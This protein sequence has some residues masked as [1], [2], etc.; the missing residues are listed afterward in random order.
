MEHRLVADFSSHCWS[1]G[2]STANAAFH[3]H[4]GQVQEMRSHT[5]YH[6]VHEMHHHI[7]RV[8]HGQAKEFQRRGYAPYAGTICRFSFI[9]LL[10]IR[11]GMFFRCWI[12]LLTVVLSKHVALDCLEEILVLIC[13]AVQIDGFMEELRSQALED[14]WP[15]IMRCL[16]LVMAS[17]K[18]H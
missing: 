3:D 16:S 1:E 5:G 9:L 4:K 8:A 10:V 13:L 12:T 15:C 6:R 7:A 14:T 18:P 2:Q 17:S 11:Q